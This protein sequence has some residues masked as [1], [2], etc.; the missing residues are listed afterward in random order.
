MLSNSAL[1]EIWLYEVMFMTLS[2]RKRTPGPVVKLKLLLIRIEKNCG[3]LALMLLYIF[4][5]LCC[6]ITYRKKR[7]I[8]NKL[9]FFIIL[10]VYMTFWHD[11]K[12]NAGVSKIGTFWK[13]KREQNKCLRNSC[14]YKTFPNFSKK[15]LKYS[16]QKRCLRCN[17]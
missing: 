9:F 5:L 14:S 12:C 7:R 8:S 10:S 4:H 3:T 13:K 6:K 2:I 11:I 15:K 1:I 17:F 16:R